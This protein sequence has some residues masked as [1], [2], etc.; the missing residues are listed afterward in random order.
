MFAY[1]RGSTLSDLRADADILLR[2]FSK[3]ASSLQL[4][5]LRGPHIYSR[6]VI[7]PIV[8]SSEQ[9]HSDY[10]QRSRRNSELQMILNYVTNTTQS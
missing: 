7:D 9:L 2:R 1:I 6:S 3:P 10:P 5:R 4:V 8:E